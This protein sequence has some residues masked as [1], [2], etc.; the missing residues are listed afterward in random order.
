MTDWSR[1]PDRTT[2]DDGQAV[3]V[4]EDDDSGLRTQNAA[5]KILTVR[6]GT[7]TGCF[8]VVVVF[9][10]GTR[11]Q[12]PVPYT[13]RYWY[14]DD[15]EGMI[16]TTGTDSTCSCSTTAGSQSAHRQVAEQLQ[17]DSANLATLSP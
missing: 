4:M 1:T 6:T 2:T 14:E 13:Y 7:S 11:Y 15:D 17:I 12:V 9:K 5:R 16:R 10:L 8:V 3:P